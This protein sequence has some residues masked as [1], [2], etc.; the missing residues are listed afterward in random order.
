MDAQTDRSGKKGAVQFS[1]L[2][3]HHIVRHELLRS[4]ITVNPGSGNRNAMLLYL[5]TGT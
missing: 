2:L 4:V 3:Y 5:E 1:T